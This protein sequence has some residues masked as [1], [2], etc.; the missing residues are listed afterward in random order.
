MTTSISSFPI[1]TF[2]RAINHFGLE[3]TEDAVERT[4]AVVGPRIDIIKAISIGRS[5]GVEIRPAV[6]APEDLI[7]LAKMTPIIC[8]DRAGQVLYVKSIV[9]NNAS[10]TVITFN[11][12]DDGQ[13]PE[14]VCNADQFGKIFSGCLLTLRPTKRLD[15]IVMPF[16]FDWLKSA[17]RSESRLARDIVLSSAIISVLGLIPAFT[18]MLVMDRVI[19]NH[20]NSTLYVIIVLVVMTMLFDMFLSFASNILLET[21]ATRIDGKM[22]LYIFDRLLNLPMQYFESTEN[23]VILGKLFKVFRIR[24][25]I[26]GQLLR[27]CLDMINLIIFVP[28]LFILNWPLAFFV[29]FCAAAIF[30]IIAVFMPHVSRRH[31]EH[32]Q[33]EIRKN[34]FLMETVQ[35]IKT[36]KSLAL[37]GRRRVEWD[38]HVANALTAKQALGQ[39]SNYP[40]SLTRPLERSISTGSILIGAAVALSQPNLIYPGM[41][42]AFS[43]I[44]GRAAGPLVSMATLTE[45]VGEVTTEMW[46]VASV[47]NAPPE[48]ARTGTGLKQT[49]SGRVEFQNVEYAYAPGLPLALNGAS[50]TIEQGTM[51][52]IM[53]RSGSGKTT[54]TRLLQGLSS[55]YSGKI[56]LDGMDLKEVELSHLRS[57]LGVVLQENFLFRGTIRE[58]IAIARPYAKFS[59]IIAAAQL[60]GAEEFI[61]RQPRGYDT[62]LEEGGS[63]LSGGQRQRLALARALLIEPPILILDEATSALDPESEAIINANI[64]RIAKERT[65]ICVSHRLSMLVPADQI[66]VMERGRVYDIGSHQELLY[67]CDIYRSMWNQQNDHSQHQPKQKLLLPASKLQPL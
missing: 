19:T 50:F 38:Q 67:R 21:L 37:E 12:G 40:R 43:M 20:S 34:S 17:V 9:T 46:E 45:Q 32:T 26:T 25:F 14:T 22:N 41:L 31:F 57:N 56:K 35:G 1:A 7:R 42:I 4:F 58:N 11:E 36:V 27:T 63:N 60:A 6:C 62:Y 2:L 29:F 18:T 5:L 23:G 16:G 51:F 55:E 64:A 44:A 53:G 8:F 65:V 33:A 48:D 28:I 66:L 52:G 54:I 59:E 30:A 3:V 13:V 10:G 24:D 15:A 47:V 39:I 61:E 49:V